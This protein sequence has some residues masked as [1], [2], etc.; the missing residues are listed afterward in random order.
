MLEVSFLLYKIWL[1]LAFVALCV[2]YGGSLDSNVARDPERWWGL[3]TTKRTQRIIAIFVFLPIFSGALY[4]LIQGW[5]DPFF[6]WPN[7]TG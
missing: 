6:T 3:R 5:L 2:F 1:F 4:I 7:I